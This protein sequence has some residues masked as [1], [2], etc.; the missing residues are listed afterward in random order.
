M[1]SIT[2]DIADFYIYLKNGNNKNLI[3]KTLAYDTRITSI[4]SSELDALNFSDDIQLCILAK[5]SDGIILGLFE[6]QCIKLP[7][8]FK[9]VMKKFNK[10]PSTFFK[11]FEQDRKNIGKNAIVLSKGPTLVFSS[12]LTAIMSMRLIYLFM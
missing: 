12:F 8:N 10:R 3:E 6:S 9:A 2:K 11:I 7:S 1:S 5:N 4:A